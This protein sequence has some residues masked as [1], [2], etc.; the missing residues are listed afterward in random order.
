MPAVTGDERKIMTTISDETRRSLVIGPDGI[1]PDEQ[2]A[3]ARATVGFL[4]SPGDEVCL[5][6]LDHIEA[7][8]KATA[9]AKEG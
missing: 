2:L 1:I 8:R 6:L 9:A 5:A 7:E 3:K 4:P